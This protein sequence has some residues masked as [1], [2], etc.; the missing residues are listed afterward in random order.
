MPDSQTRMPV[1]STAAMKLSRIFTRLVLF[2]FVVF[3]VAGLGIGY[4]FHK[5]CPSIKLER[6]NAD[7]LT[8]WLLLRDFRSLDSSTQEE[9]LKAYL[10]HFGPNSKPVEKNNVYGAALRIAAKYAGE[11]N[12]RVAQWGAT[13]PKRLFARNEYAVS[14]ADLERVKGQFIVSSEVVATRQ[15]LQS[16]QT[17]KYEVPRPMTKTE[18]N[19]RILT[20]R[21]FLMRMNEYDRKPDKEKVAFLE[22]LTR[23]LDW[24]QNYYNDFLVAMGLERDGELE[25]LRELSLLVCSWYEGTPPDELARV[26]WFKDLV[27]SVAVLQRA[28]IRD[29]SAVIPLKHGVSSRLNRMIRS[30]RARE[31]AVLKNGVPEHI[32]AGIIGTSVQ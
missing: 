18:G 17:D 31:G 32:D 29:Y 24:W 14:V 27:V 26:L 3:C 19:C 20:K 9:L 15:L 4:W 6:A 11:R 21:W 10:E 28:G 2:V 30:F 22:E 5:Y 7:V 1:P 25:L 16:L 12:R 23:E 13:R 8:G